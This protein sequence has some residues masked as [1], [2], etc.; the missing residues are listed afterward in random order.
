MNN[1]KASPHIGEMSPS[2]FPS[3]I[4][5]RALLA[6]QA[7]VF[8]LRGY[9]R[10]L[11]AANSTS[12]T[13]RAGAA[14]TGV[15]RVCDTLAIVYTR[16]QPHVVAFDGAAMGDTV[17]SFGELAIRAGMGIVTVQLSQLADAMEVEASHGAIRSACVRALFGECPPGIAEVRRFVRDEFERINAIWLPHRRTGEPGPARDERTERYRCAIRDA[18]QA[19]I[20]VG[21]DPDVARFLRAGTMC[22]HP[23][24]RAACMRI[25]LAFHISLYVEPDRALLP[26]PFLDLPYEPNEPPNAEHR[27]PR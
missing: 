15:R 27:K 9:A 13:A 2:A 7:Q 8:H 22:P 5:L 1:A 18:Q 12:D 6:L 3:D 19:V 17:R 14:A 20:A 26:R 23:T 11:A 24:V 4:V 16:L 25:T 21:H 10:Q